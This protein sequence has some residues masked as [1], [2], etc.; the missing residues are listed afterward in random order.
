MLTS[1]G[2]RFASWQLARRCQCDLACRILNNIGKIK[3]RQSQPADALGLFDKAHSRK[4]GKTSV[5]IM[6]R[7]A[8][9]AHHTLCARCYASGCGQGATQYSH[10]ARTGTPRPACRSGACPPFRRQPSFAWSSHRR[11]ESSDSLRARVDRALAYS[12][13]SKEKGL[14]DLMESAVFFV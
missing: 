12:A 1:Q 7:R 9:A 5:S 6:R 10:R 14:E 11:R 2:A 13:H 4:R 8:G 3:A